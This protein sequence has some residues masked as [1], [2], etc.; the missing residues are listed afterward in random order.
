MIGCRAPAGGVRAVNDGV[1]PGA[2]TSGIFGP[3]IGTGPY[4]VVAIVQMPPSAPTGQAGIITLNASGV[5]HALMVTPQG[6]F[7]FYTVGGTATSPIDVT[8]P[9]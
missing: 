4:T 8:S 3:T 5:A 9:N 1:T 2:I 6:E 7:F